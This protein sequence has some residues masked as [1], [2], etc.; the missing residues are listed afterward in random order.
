MTVAASGQRWEPPRRADRDPAPTAGWCGKNARMRAYSVTPLILA[1][2]TLAALAGGEGDS[3]SSSTGDEPHCSEGWGDGPEV[4][5]DY[6]PCGCDVSKCEYGGVCRFSGDVSPSTWTASL[7]HPKC[8]C[9]DPGQLDCAEN[10]C[11]MLG[12]VKPLCS[13]GLC[14]LR[15]DD[16]DPCPSGYACSGNNT[17]QVKLE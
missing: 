11:P 14:T 13:D 6:P 8:E 16:S 7:C 5:P 2:L 17:C 10:N 1:T 9:V 4:D 3:S 12:G 15:C